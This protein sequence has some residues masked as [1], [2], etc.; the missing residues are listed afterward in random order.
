MQL[1]VE[2]SVQARNLED[3]MVITTP[4]LV[5]T[6]V[7]FLHTS[8]II[9]CIIHPV[10]SCVHLNPI[11]DLVRSLTSPL[12]FLCSICPLAK[13]RGRNFL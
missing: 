8:L 3:I 4:D 12:S 5:F 11:L 7:I 9:L 6:L 1:N 13:L 2:T 10:P